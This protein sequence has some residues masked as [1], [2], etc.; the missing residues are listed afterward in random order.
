[1]AI[2][3]IFWHPS[4]KQA[5]SSTIAPPHRFPIRSVIREPRPIQPRYRQPRLTAT[6]LC[7]PSI[8]HSIT[9]VQIRLI[10]RHINA[11]LGPCVRLTALTSLRQ[12]NAR[13]ATVWFMAGPCRFPSRVAET[14]MRSFRP[15]L[16]PATPT[17]LP[18]RFRKPIG[19]FHKN[20]A[21]SDYFIVTIREAI[22]PHSD[23][24]VT[25]GGEQVVGHPRKTKLG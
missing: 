10:H 14:T 19:L 8:L 6:M 3:I 24:H 13:A 20:Q 18:F 4:P 5:Y 1:M 22:H 16:R 15:L 12:P 2:K 23:R 7:L 11:A 21:S 9:P 25:A 17:V